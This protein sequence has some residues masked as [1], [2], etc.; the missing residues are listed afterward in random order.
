MGIL[1][2]Y[3]LQKL[4]KNFRSMSIFSLSNYPN[5]LH[6]TEINEFSFQMNFNQ[7]FNNDHF[8]TILSF[9]DNYCFT[10]THLQ[11]FFIFREIYRKNSDKYCR[12]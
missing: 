8:K 9:T 2:I 4:D 11:R 5:I 7:I 1:L 12:I 10:L 3:R 6:T